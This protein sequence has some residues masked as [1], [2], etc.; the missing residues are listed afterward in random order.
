MKYRPERLAKQI[1][2]ELTEIIDA[3]VKD[4]RVLGV[5]VVRAEMNADLSMAK[6][7]VA[8][9]G[10]EGEQRQALKAL[11]QAT[12]FIKRELATRLQVRQLPDLSYHLDRSL[13][14]VLQIEELLSQIKKERDEDDTEPD[15]ETP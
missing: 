7:W 4:P 13:D 9:S 11:R 5:T 3:K 10:D 12:G 14:N 6:V 2:T 1:Q 8:V 15:G